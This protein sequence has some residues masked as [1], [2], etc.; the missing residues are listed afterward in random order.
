[1]AQRLNSLDRQESNEPRPIA[2]CSSLP[3]RLLPAGRAVQLAR[4]W[5]GGL[6]SGVRLGLRVHSCSFEGVGGVEARFVHVVG[7]PHE[8]RVGEEDVVAAAGLHAVAP[9]GVAELDGLAVRVHRVHGV[10]EVVDGGGLRGRVV[11]APLGC[12]SSG[13]HRQQEDEDLRAKSRPVSL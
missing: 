7:D 13:R 11:V 4:G 12:C 1:M 8:A 9:F 3:R 5:E 10:A 2:G 6:A